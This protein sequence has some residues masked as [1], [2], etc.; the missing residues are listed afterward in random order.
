MKPFETEKLLK[1]KDMVNKT[2]MGKYLHQP[3]KKQGW[4]PNYKELKKLDI[5]IP[6]N[7]INKQDIDLKREFSTVVFQIS[8]RH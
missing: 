2:K 6:S 1:A 4:S 8:K 5:K 3:H 7:P